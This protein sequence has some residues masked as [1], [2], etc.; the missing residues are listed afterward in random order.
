MLASPPRQIYLG[1]TATYQSPH[2]YSSQYR[3]NPAQKYGVLRLVGSLKLDVSFAEY[4][5]FYMG[6]F[7]KETY[8][9][10][11]AY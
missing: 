4:S 6:S 3:D 5:R 2:P 10:E 1:A 9:F 11:G 7:A 8:K